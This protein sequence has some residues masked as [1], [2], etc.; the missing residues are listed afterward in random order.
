MK[1]PDINTLPDHTQE[2]K[3]IS[4]LVK[5]AYA[6]LLNDLTLNRVTDLKRKMYKYIFE[7]YLYEVADLSLTRN[8]IRDELQVYYNKHYTEGN[9]LGTKLYYDEY[10][11]LH[12]D[13]D[14]VKRNIWKAIF[15]IDEEKVI[16]SNI[17]V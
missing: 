10:F 4:S 6:Q 3:S 17:L 16:Q 13:Y 7:C 8:A 12:K 5:K 11:D 1:K 15:K 2:L 9:A 14:K